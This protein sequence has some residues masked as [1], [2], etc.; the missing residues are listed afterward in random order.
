MHLQRL[1]IQ[2]LPTL[3]LSA[4]MLPAAS[5]KASQPPARPSLRLPVACM[6]GES[7]FVQQYPDHDPGPGARDYR[8]GNRVY[9]GHDGTDIRLPDLAAQRR[10][11][12]V[13]A[14]AAGTVLAVRDGEADH[15]VETDAD[16]AALSGR[17]CG[18]GVLIDHGGGWQTQYCH[19]AKGSIAVAAGQSVAA[20][21][22]LG[23]VGLSGN[24]Q[25]PHLHL[26]VRRVD[27]AGAQPID[28][29][30][31]DLEPGRCAPTQ[32]ATLWDRKTAKALAYRAVDVLNAGFADG[33]VTMDAI[34]QQAL[35]A[36]S[37]GSAI[38]Y[39]GRAIGIAAGDTITVRIVGPDGQVMASNEAAP[40]SDKAQYLLFTGKKRP[41]GGWPTGRYAGTITVTRA[42][43]AVVTAS[44]ALHLQGEAIS[45]ETR[46]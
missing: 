7:C 43:V 41:A 5:P 27:P 4:A 32:G 17:E 35:S 36:P 42:G 45:D 13:L 20:G 21:D 1:I 29:F 26:A 40:D 39:Y 31:P 25:F 38:V 9:D 24:T 3:L 37:A 22:R 10:G 44:H 18:N 30:A 15:L 12:A 11:V 46:R 19:M 6:P 2:A 14:A 34:E 33:P 8:C 23:N 28:P 16:R